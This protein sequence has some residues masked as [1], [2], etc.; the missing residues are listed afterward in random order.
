MLF[1][2]DCPLIC[3][4]L[5]GFFGKSSNVIIKVAER[6]IILPAPFFIRKTTCAT[7]L[8]KL[9]SFFFCSSIRFCSIRLHNQCTPSKKFRSVQGRIQKRVEVN[10]SES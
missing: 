2:C 9:D 3:R 10:G 4:D 6:N 8:D 1:F 5:A 7:F